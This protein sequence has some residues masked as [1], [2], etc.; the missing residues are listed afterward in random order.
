MMT[1]E[2]LEIAEFLVTAERDRAILQDVWV[3][4]PVRPH[5]GTSVALSQKLS[6]WFSQGINWAIQQDG[7][8]GF[9]E[10]SRAAMVGR[11]LD[12]RSEKYLL[13]IDNDTEPPLNLPWLLA[14]H[15]LPLVG[16]LIPSVGDRGRMMLCVTKPDSHGLNR[17]VDYD[18][19][20]KIPAVGVAEV[21]H[22][23]SGAILIRRDVAESFTWKQ[24][25]VS[26]D[27]DIP[28]LVPDRIRAE[29]AR[30]GNVKKGEDIWFCDQVRS[31]GFSVHVDVEAL[32]VHRK[33][34]RLTF[35]GQLRD[36][37][38]SVE[39]WIAPRAG[40]PVDQ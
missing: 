11:F 10:I 33:T 35:P 14:R 22:V 18:G 20:D 23:G 29:G 26:G 21:S 12:E 34:V 6:L 4:I 9:I 24:D 17:F 40:R 30:S 13:M 25:P 5:D 27:W 38:L 1:P 7:M 39:D 37:S 16:T 3:L 28:F 32:A 2:E 8:G 15:N 36:P 19:G 31:K